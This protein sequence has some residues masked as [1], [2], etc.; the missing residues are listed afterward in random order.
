MSGDSLHHSS[1]PEAHG[2]VDQEF[3]RI[4]DFKNSLSNVDAVRPV[5]AEF[6][7]SDPNPVGGVISRF[8]NYEEVWSLPTLY[9]DAAKPSEATKDMKFHERVSRD[10]GK[11]KHG[12]F[13]G[14]LEFSNGHSVEVAVKP[15]LD[16]VRQSCLTD[17]FNYKA[18]ADLGINTLEPFGFVLG[19]EGKAYSLTVLDRSLKTFDSIDWSEFYPQIDRNPGM[20]NMW[21]Q[22]AL[23]TAI[24]HSMGRLN[25]GDEAPRNMANTAGGHNFL[26]DWEH[27]NI[28]VLPVNDAEIRF[29]LSYKDLFAVLEGCILPPVP[30]YK[31]GIGIF[32]GKEGDWWQ[33]FEEMFF[34]DYR[35]ARLDLAASGKHH[36][37]RQKE[38]ESELTELERSL[39]AVAQDLQ[40]S[41]AGK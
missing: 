5:T 11:S 13:F 21:T 39:R 7:F 37:L 14:D 18:V 38:V 24:I 31:E 8:G 2:S 6:D 30:G 40:Q 1:S 29:G 35:E 32:Y 12:V 16:D 26:F 4:Q 27:A 20:A 19:E 41:L 25:M 22:I 28:N 3:I 15:H 34:A 33:G 10:P 36:M 17:Y 23:Q 9:V